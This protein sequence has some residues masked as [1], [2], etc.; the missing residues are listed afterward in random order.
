MNT[1]QPFD[2][3]PAPLARAISNGAEGN[4][5]THVACRK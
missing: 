4:M 1:A 3:A 2:M 5:D